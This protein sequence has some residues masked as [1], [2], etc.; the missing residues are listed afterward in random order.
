METERRC[1]E[2][3][4]RGIPL[5]ARSKLHFIARNTRCGKRHT[6]EAAVNRQLAC[7]AGTVKLNIQALGAARAGNNNNHQIDLSQS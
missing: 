5:Y 7:L 6:K 1:F 3:G 4:S 2:S